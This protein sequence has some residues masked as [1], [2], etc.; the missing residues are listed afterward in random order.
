MYELWARNRKTMRYEKISEFDDE[1][2]KFFMIDQIDQSIYFEAM[3]VKK[4]QSVN[5]EVVL[6][7]EFKEYKPYRKEL[8]NEHEG[9]KR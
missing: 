9:R 3:I 4:S 1:R 6:Y 8:K 2:Q 7:E 5:Q